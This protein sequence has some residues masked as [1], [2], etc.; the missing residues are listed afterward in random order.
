MKI[1]VVLL[2]IKSEAHPESRAVRKPLSSK[3]FEYSEVHVL[4]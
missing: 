2:R 3:H 1:Y 4:Q